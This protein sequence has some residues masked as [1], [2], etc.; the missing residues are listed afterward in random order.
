MTVLLLPIPAGV[1]ANGGE[2][3]LQT[4]SGPHRF[5]VELATTERE[6]R[7]GLM[8]RRSLADDGGML[9]LYDEPQPISMWMKNTPISLDMIFISPEGKVHRIEERTEPFSTAPVSSGGAVL[10]ILEVKAGTA[11]AIG[12]KPGDEVILPGLG[13]T[14]KP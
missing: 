10:G 13:G 7:L 6:R 1:A 2:V 12:L 5:A 4:D 3:V 11:K 8:Y 9:F 14:R